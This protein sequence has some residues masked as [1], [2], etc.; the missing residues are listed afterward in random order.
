MPRGSSQRIRLRLTFFLRPDENI[1]DYDRGELF[2]PNCWGYRLGPTS[3]EG[4]ERGQ[5]QFRCLATQWGDFYEVKGDLL[6]NRIDD[7]I[8]IGPRSSESGRHFL[9]YFK[10][11]TFECDAREWSFRVLPISDADYKRL[12]AAEVRITLPRTTVL[13]LMFDVI[14]EPF[15]WTIRRYRR[16]KY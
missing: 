2:F 12:R 11:D 1:R 5:C 7:W 14:A 13:G 3:D 8:V 4:W 9:F 15:R 6:E 16:T 10:D